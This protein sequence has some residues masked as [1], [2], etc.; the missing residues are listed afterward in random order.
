VEALRS[1]VDGMTTP[2]NTKDLLAALKNVKGLTIGGGLL[3]EPW[4]TEDSSRPAATARIAENY[5][6]ITYLQ[7]SGDWQLSTAKTLDLPALLS[8]S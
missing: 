3:P 5:E 6:Y 7:P 2:I 4:T 1:V 8:G